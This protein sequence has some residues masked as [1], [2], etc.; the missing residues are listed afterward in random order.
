MATFVA[1]AVF[2]CLRWLRERLWTMYG[3]LGAAGLA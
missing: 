1:L 3:H 2:K